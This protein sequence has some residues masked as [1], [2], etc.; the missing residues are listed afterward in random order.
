M[1]IKSYTTMVGDDWLFAIKQPPGA[2]GWTTGVGLVQ[3]EVIH[4]LLR[5]VGSAEGR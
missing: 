4:S 2:S 5:G 1:R 3:L